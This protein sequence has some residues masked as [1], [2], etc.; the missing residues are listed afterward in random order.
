MESV[1]RNWQVLY[2]CLWACVELPVIWDRYP[3]KADA[4]LFGCNLE[5]GK[6][7]QQREYVASREEGIQRNDFETNTN[8][9]GTIYLDRH[10]DFSI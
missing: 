6:H 3:L 1:R 5:K 7:E 9:R 10:F 8:Q 4:G 2:M